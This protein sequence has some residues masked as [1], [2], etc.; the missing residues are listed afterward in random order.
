M[1]RRRYLG[2]AGMLAVLIG[3]GL[4]VTMLV[5]DGPGVTKAN[6]DRIH[7][8]MTKD[9]VMEILG[10]LPSGDFG[11]A[12]VWNDEDGLIVVHFDTRDIVVDTEWLSHLPQK[13]LPEKLRRWLGL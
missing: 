5:A 6:F 11:S 8:G 4:G 9:R 2:V 7:N 10:Q 13:T 1:T 3:A 12:E